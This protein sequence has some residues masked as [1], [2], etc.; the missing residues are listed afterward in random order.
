MDI[1]TKRITEVVC[2][3]TKSPPLFSGLAATSLLEHL[4]LVTIA[5]WVQESGRSKW[6]PSEVTHSGGHQVSKVRLRKR[7]TPLRIVKL[8]HG[9]TI[10]VEL[11]YHGCQ[12]RCTRGNDF[13][14][15][16]VDLC[17]CI[18]GLTEETD[19]EKNHTKRVVVP[20]C[21]LIQFVQFKKCTNCTVADNY[22]EVTGH[23]EHPNKLE[24]DAMQLRKWF[25]NVERGI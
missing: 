21:S 18:A 15:V 1:T 25:M 10:M 12:S 5:E 17:L 23:K 13:L 9:L 20:S 8:H 2:L 22:L 19:T 24:T 14:I 4:D 6:P 3:N 11:L 16:L 7:N